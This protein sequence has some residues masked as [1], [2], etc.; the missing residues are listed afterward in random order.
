MKDYLEQYALSHERLTDRQL[1]NGL[2][3]ALH[4]N[5]GRV[6]G[7]AK[8]EFERRFAGKDPSDACV[9]V[10][11]STGGPRSLARGVSGALRLRGYL[12]SRTA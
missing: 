1:A 2:R 8:E 12:T 9:S 5:Y 7:A 4:H 11:I 6:C 3:K 10:R